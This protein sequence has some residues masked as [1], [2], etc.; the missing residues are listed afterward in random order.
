MKD[1]TLSRIAGLFEIE[2]RRPT[3][4]GLEYVATAEKKRQE[5]QANFHSKRFIFYAKQI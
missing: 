3:P 5:C 1:M 4:S 2:A